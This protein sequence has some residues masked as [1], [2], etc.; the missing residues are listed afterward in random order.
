MNVRIDTNS[1]YE[2]FT[3]HF[4]DNDRILF[5]GSFG[6][7]KS[8]FLSE[9]FLKRKDCNVFKIYPVSYSVSQ[10]EDIFELIKFDILFTLIEDFFD[11][12]ELVNED[13]S[14]IL[15]FQLK[16]LFQAKWSP[17]LF[18]LIELADKTGKSSA[19]Q[20]ISGEIN[21]QYSE[22]KTKFKNEEDDIYGYMYQQY[23]KGGSP[24]ENDLISQLIKELL[25]RV[26]KNTTFSENEEGEQIEKLNILIIDDLDRL[27]PEHIFRLFNIFSVNF[28]SCDIINKF[29]FD[30]IIFVCDIL[31]IRE[32]YAHRYGRKTDFEGYIDKFY[33]SS[34]FEFSTNN[35]LHKYLKEILLGY[36]LPHQVP[37]FTEEN[38]VNYN[39]VYIILKATLNA[40]LVAKKINLR[41]L[42]NNN[43][44][45]INEEIIN[46]GSKNRYYNMQYPLFIAFSILKKIYDS[47][48][49]LREILIDLEHLDKERFRRQLDYTRIY[50]DDSYKVLVDACLPFLV[51]YKDVDAKVNDLRFTSDQLN[52]KQKLTYLGV[53]A[54][55]QMM[56][57]RHSNF[58]GTSYAFSF[59][60]F[61]DVN[62]DSK[63]VE[64][65]P[66]TLLRKTFDRII[67]ITTI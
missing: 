51:D 23:T 28:G 65:N 58:R 37:Q 38:N 39:P 67:S 6:T 46:V 30:R 53:V 62:D 50:D 26:K 57:E 32:I 35:I 13:Y 10:N 49:Y 41:S 19:L 45:Q 59:V 42:L 44:F 22:F 4:S 7:G 24:R 5:S 25:I 48:D 34:P 15:A 2:P 33:S 11:E 8:T 17:I 56:T 54:E 29:G 52:L 1:I 61:Y 43:D 20:K 27:D 3:R 12:S 66:F 47:S 9:Y 16:F 21:K 55:F 64:L 36:T 14:N 40:L 63:E 60:K 18:K 31:N